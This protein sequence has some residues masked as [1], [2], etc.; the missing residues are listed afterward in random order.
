MRAGAWQETMDTVA[1]VD[2]RTR[3]WTLACV[4][5]MHAYSAINTP[6]R[7]VNLAGRLAEGKRKSEEAPSSPRGPA[8]TGEWH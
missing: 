5:V 4:H 8:R 7:F 3:A 1:H 2:A 6:N